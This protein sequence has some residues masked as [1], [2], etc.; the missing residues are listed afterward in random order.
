MDTMGE[1]TL[2][3]C[4]SGASAANVWMLVHGTEL[5]GVG[6]EQ[7]HCHYGRV[8]VGTLRKW[9]ECSKCLDVSTWHWIDWCWP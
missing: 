5:T 6:L 3:R 4:E 9:G 7:K 1:Y 8:H 2:A